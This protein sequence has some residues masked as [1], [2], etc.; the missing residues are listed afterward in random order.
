MNKIIRTSGWIVSLFF[1]LLLIGWGLSVAFEDKI[2]S[3]VIKEINDN[4]QAP[5]SVQQINFSLIRHFP[6]ATLSLENVEIKGYPVAI[7]NKPML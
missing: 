3:L 2:K 1:A 4:L 5:A 7:K 6:Y